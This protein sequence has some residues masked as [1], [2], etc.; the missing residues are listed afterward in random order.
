MKKIL[1]AVGALGVMSFTT[2]QIIDTWLLSEA[3]NNVQDMRE[4]MKEDIYNGRL[5]QNVGSDYLEVLDETEDLLI[6]FNDYLNL[7]NYKLNTAEQR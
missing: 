6:D 7:A 4:W 5:D 1:I 2:N 3:L